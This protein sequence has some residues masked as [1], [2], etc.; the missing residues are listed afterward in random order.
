M[1]SLLSAITDPELGGAPFVIIRSMYG[2]SQ[3]EKVLL[4]E[5][6]YETFGAVHPAKMED[7]QLLPEE[8]RHSQ[9]LLFHSPVSLQL[10][11]RIDDEKFYAPDWILFNFQS[12]LVISVSDWS[13]L[14]FCKAYAVLQ[15]GE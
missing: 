1:I 3:G 4:S 12:F 10:G 14:G 5:D 15:R 11:G 7:L 2:L 8:Y 9:V 13:S 6:R